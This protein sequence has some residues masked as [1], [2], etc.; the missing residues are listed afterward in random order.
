MR[1]LTPVLLALWLAAGCG[2]GEGGTVRLLTHASFLVSDDV[3]AEFTETTGYELEI[4]QGAD[5][6]SVLNQAILT[7]G[8]PVADVLFGVDTT[9]LSRALGADLFDWH[10]PRSWRPMKRM[11]KSSIYSCRVI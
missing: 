7:A 5:A 11:I 2:D 8:N 10:P 9:F 6:G 1:R 4:I 3:I